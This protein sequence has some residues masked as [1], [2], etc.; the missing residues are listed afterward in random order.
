MRCSKS[1]QKRPKLPKSAVRFSKDRLCRI[2][3][4]G[5]PEDALPRQVRCGS[6]EHGEKERSAGPVRLDGGDLGGSRARDGVR[7]H[8]ERLRLQ[9]LFKQEVQKTA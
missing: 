9:L 1:A 3:S 5:E 6:Q 8:G 7:G 4:Q 2:R